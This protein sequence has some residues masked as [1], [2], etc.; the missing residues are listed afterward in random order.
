MKIKKG[1][2]YRYDNDGT[3]CG[4]SSVD[5]ED[6]DYVLVIVKDAPRRLNGKELTDWFTGQVGASLDYDNE[7]G[8]NELWQATIANV[9]RYFFGR[10]RIGAIRKLH[11]AA[12]K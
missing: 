7:R 10:T 2:Y 12:T 6:P 8:P 3:I 11:K 4:P 1:E 9:D 5:K